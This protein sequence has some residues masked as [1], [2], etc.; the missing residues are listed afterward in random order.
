MMNEVMK[1]LSVLQ[2]AMNEPWA[3][4]LLGDVIKPPKS[5]NDE[6]N[7]VVAPS[8]KSIAAVPSPVPTTTP[9]AGVVSS[10]PPETPETADPVPAAPPAPTD[11]PPPEVPSQEGVIN[12]STHRAAHARLT[13]KMNSMTTEC[14]NMQKL[15]S[16]TRKD[17]IILVEKSGL[18]K[19][20]CHISF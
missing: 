20:L 17:I 13:R 19:R 1:A 14:P 10:G 18:K 16:G 3:K 8:S 12:S 11:P 2:I 4:Q 15:W 5:S 9:T 6:K 7:H